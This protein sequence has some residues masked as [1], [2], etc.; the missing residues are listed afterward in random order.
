MPWTKLSGVDQQQGETCVF[1]VVIGL[2]GL[3]DG[4]MVMVVSETASLVDLWWSGVIDGILA[5]GL[6]F[7]SVG[8]LV[9]RLESWS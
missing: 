7:P 8:R 2:L 9:E 1:H 6:V 5:V 4:V 3:G